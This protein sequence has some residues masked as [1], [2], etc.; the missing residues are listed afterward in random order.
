MNIYLDIETLPTTDPVV[1]AELEASIK[2]PAQYKKPESIQQWLD[3]NKADALSELVGKTGLNGLYGRVCV[4]CAAVNDDEV[5]SF[6]GNDEYDLLA[7]FFAWLSDQTR[8]AAYA[9]DVFTSATFV[10]HNLAGFDLPFLKHRS[11]INRI[12]PPQ[13][14]LKA[15]NAKPWDGCIADTMLMWS[16]DREKRVSMDKLCRAFGIEG[17]GDM[18]GSKVAETWAADPLKVVDYC[19]GD[20]ERTREMY[21]RMTFRAAQQRMQEAA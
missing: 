19:V 12:Q 11:I 14:L 16:A 1:I 2:A 21:K 13:P 7:S 3:E 6:P 17:K 18:E 10:G 5:C 4:I 9:S 20:V 8:V 15:M